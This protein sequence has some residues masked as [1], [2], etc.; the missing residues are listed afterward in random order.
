MPDSMDVLD[1]DMPKTRSHYYLWVTLFLLLLLVTY[2]APNLFYPVMPGQAGVI[3]RPFSNGTDTDT[4]YGEGLWFVFPGNRM[5]LYDC[6]VQE[7]IETVN[8]LSFNGLTIQVAVSYRFRPIR[9]EL[10]LLHRDIGPEYDRIIVTPAVYAAVREV[11]GKY[12]P[13]E[14]YTSHRITVQEEINHTAREA[15]N[16]RHIVFDSIVIRSIQLPELINT[17]IECK[18]RQ[19]Q[20]FQE[21]EFLIAK[22]QREA[23][24]MRIEAEGIKIYQ[25]IVSANLPDAYLTW[26]SIDATLE[27]AKSENSKVVVIGGSNAQGLSFPLEM[28]T[29]GRRSNSGMNDMDAPVRA[30]E[31]RAAASSVHMPKAP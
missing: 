19:Q 3:Y 30:I 24:R 14:L 5:Y 13:E 12:R 8:V 17:A 20:E 16:G 6:R 11:V 9:N 29:S 23:D 1:D 4:I 28:G 31:K 27:L 10:P 22:Q 26:K 18:L 7:K 2:F 21:Y 25:D 15:V